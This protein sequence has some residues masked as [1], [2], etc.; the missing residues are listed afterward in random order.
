[1]AKRGF[2]VLKRG[3]NWEMGRMEDVEIVLTV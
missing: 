3:L 1:M 2:H